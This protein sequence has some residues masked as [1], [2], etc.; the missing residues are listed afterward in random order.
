MDW[1]RLNLGDEDEIRAVAVI[2]KTLS[3]R[4]V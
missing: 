1:R 3:R 4:D 2:F